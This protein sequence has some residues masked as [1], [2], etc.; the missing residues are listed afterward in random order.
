[1][2]RVRGVSS[3]GNVSDWTSVQVTRFVPTPGAITG[4]N[5]FACTDRGSQ[6]YTGPAVA[7]AQQYRWTLPTN[8]TATTPNPSTTPSI[9]VI[10]SGT[11]VGTLSV[12]AEVTNPS[13]VSQ[14]SNLP[15]SFV[16]LTVGINGAVSLCSTGTAYSAI[17]NYTTTPMQY[18]WTAS[19]NVTLSS[20]T[21]PNNTAAPNGTGDGW[22]RLTVTDACGQATTYQH[23][24]KV[25]APIMPFNGI[26][27]ES[28][29]STNTTSSITVCP[30]TSVTFR[31]APTF[32]GEVISYEWRVTY[33]GNT[34]ASHNVSSDP[35]KSSYHLVTSYFDTRAFF[36][37]ECRVISTCGSSA[38]ARTS[39]SNMD[40]SGGEEPWFVYPNPA[41]DEVTLIM[42]A[43]VDEADIQV[44]DME[45]NT[46]SKTKIRKNNN[47]ISVR[48]IKAGNYF[49]II[50]HKDGTERKPLMI[51]R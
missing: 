32:A 45:G 29:L 9:T 44:V 6:T 50:T 36:E 22:I 34:A 7:G 20:S 24:V 48:N 17:V 10:P 4:K 19:S 25:G 46:V 40:C 1:M 41:E 27:S 8:W 21:G 26:R 37:I 43:S 35:Q 16:P 38:W 51:K 12:R 5:V 23:N 11:T 13:L 2:V 42:A 3:C 49:I 47:K 39:V 30:G 28:Y 14:P 18:S 15:I 31:P 33:G